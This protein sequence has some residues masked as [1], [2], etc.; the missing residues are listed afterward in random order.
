MNS[1]YTDWRALFLA[2]D[3]RISRGPWWLADGLL[4]ALSAVY[5]TVAG[6]AVKLASFWLVYPALLFFATCVC[7]KRLHDRGRSGWWAALVLG[8]FLAV[9]P[10]PRAASAI[11]AA[12]VL[13]WTLVELG[14]MPGEQ[15]ANRFGPSP[16]AQ[17]A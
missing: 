10:M 13:V 12:P 1:G 16:G 15:G 11:V 14:L 6:P 2:A 17:A 9:W 5:E 4:L 8:G 7:S 3:G